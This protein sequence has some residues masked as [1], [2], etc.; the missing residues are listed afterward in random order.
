M[1]SLKTWK[2]LASVQYRVALRRMRMQQGWFIRVVLGLMMI[3]SAFILL[4]L[5]FFFDRFSTEVWPNKPVIEVVNQFL[6]AAF[7]SLFFVRFLFQKTPRISIVPYLHM[8]IGRQSLVW[9]FQ[10]ASLFL[11]IT[12]IRYCFLSRSGF[13]TSA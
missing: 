7:V 10:G 2:M 4:T 5:G 3:Y 12:S 13:D 1:T 9:F 11:S 8:P 6:L